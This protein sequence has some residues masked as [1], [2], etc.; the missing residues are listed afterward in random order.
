[1][2]REAAVV[3]LGSRRFMFEPKASKLFRD[4]DLFASGVFLFEAARHSAKLVVVVGAIVLVGKIMDLITALT[5][6]YK[7]GADAPH[8]LV[9][10]SDLLALHLPAGAGYGQ[11]NADCETRPCPSG[12]TF[13]MHLLSLLDGG[14]KL[15]LVS[16][17]CKCIIS[18]TA[19]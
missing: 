9:T 13:H 19:I 6:A 3:P 14:T 18:N 7:L 12:P 11:R 15:P 5:T 8:L 10:G 1:M 16:A 17:T 4:T 2:W